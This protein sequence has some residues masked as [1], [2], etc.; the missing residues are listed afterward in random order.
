MHK[1]KT[2]SNLY[3][4]S[5]EWWQKLY[6]KHNKR[7]GYPG[8]GNKDVPFQTLPPEVHPLNHQEQSHQKSHQQQ[9]SRPRYSA[10]SEMGISIRVGKT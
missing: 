5:I 6:L 2:Y 3:N 7:P 10:K 8:G 4:I 9:L 1:D